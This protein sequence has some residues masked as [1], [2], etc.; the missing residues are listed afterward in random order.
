[1]GRAAMWGLATGGEDGVADVLQ[2]LG[3]ELDAAL[4]TCGCRSPREATPTLVASRG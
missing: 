3:D 1:V 2:V 4:A